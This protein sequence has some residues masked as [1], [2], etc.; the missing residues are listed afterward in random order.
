MYRSNEVTLSYQSCSSVKFTMFYFWN[1]LNVEFLGNVISMLFCL[2]CIQL[3]HRTTQYPRRKRLQR[4]LYRIIFSSQ[5]WFPARQ[6]NLFQRCKHLL[7]WS[8]LSLGGNVNTRRMSKRDMGYIFYI[9]NLWNILV[10]GNCQNYHNLMLLTSS[11]T[12]Q[13][14]MHLILFTNSSQR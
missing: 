13:T 7:Y 1:L 3:T 4:I 10:T 2:G 9:K 12:K 5:S 14:L 8:I 6:G 11:E